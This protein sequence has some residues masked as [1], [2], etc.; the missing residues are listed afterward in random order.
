MTTNFYIGK[1]IITVTKDKCQLCRAIIT[2]KCVAA[3]SYIDKVDVSFHID[4]AKTLGIY[5]ENY[6]YVKNNITYPV[7]CSRYK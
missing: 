5:N 3:T 7:V 6:Q 4:C 1:A 2:G